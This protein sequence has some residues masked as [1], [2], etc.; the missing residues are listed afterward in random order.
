MND[1]VELPVVVVTDDAFGTRVRWYANVDEAQ[2]PWLEHPLMVDAHGV[3]THLALHRVPPAVLA[4]A[5]AAFETL[6]TDPGAN[7]SHLA[8]HRRVNELHSATELEP[9]GGGS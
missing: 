3:I 8:T 1:V 5:N 4:V 7:L 9:I 6:R 2:Q